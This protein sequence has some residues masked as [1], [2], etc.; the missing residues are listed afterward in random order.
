MKRERMDDTRVAL[1]VGGGSGIGAATARRL[2]DAG[3]GVGVMSSSGRGEQLGGELG[4]LG[5]TGSN[6]DSDDLA[7]VRRRGDGP[8]GAHRRRRQLH[9]PRAER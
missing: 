4:G 2:A 6:L 9:R 8:V 7:R 5:F 3:Y 1:V